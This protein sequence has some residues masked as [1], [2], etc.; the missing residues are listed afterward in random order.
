[1]KREPYAPPG[2]SVRLQGGELGESQKLAFES[3]VDTASVYLDGSHRRYTVPFGTVVTFS[4]HKQPLLL[5]RP[6]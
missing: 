2:S 1:M 3:R 4:L 5:V 6:R